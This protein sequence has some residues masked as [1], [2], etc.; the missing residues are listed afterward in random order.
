[1]SSTFLDFKQKLTSRYFASNVSADCFYC[2]CASSIYKIIW[3]TFEVVNQLQ[4]GNVSW[5][6]L[7]ITF[8]M[9]VLGLT[10]YKTWVQTTNSRCGN[11]TSFHRKNNEWCLT[12]LENMISPQLNFQQKFGLHGVGFFPLKMPV[13]NDQTVAANSAS[14][15][16]FMY[17][18]LVIN[19]SL[20]SQYSGVLLMQHLR[21]VASK[22][23]SLTQKLSKI[24]V[25][26]Y[27]SK[28]HFW[29]VIAWPLQTIPFKFCL[30]CAAFWDLILY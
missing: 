13:Q 12:R 15:V 20:L 23:S 22:S 5:T 4:F 17:C 16:A 18:Y 26:C 14:Y 19:H 6:F 30:T 28:I 3:S 10:T 21:V 27:F 8:V 2:W 29:D 25:I 9:K 1:M 11:L 7:R 24:A